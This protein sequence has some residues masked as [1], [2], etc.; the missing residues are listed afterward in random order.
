VIKTQAAEFL[1]QRSLAP[2]DRRLLCHP[3]GQHGQAQ[4]IAGQLAQ[5]LNFLS[6]EKTLG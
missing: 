5:L 6:R 3:A 1:C 2:L 4:A